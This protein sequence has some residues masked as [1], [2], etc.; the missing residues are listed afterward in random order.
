MRSGLRRTYERHATPGGRGQPS[1]LGASRMYDTTRA[2]LV[3]VRQPLSSS[4]SPSAACVCSLCGHK[5]ARRDAPDVTGHARGR[6]DLPGPA[7]R[8]EPDGGDTSTWSCERQGLV[9]QDTHAGCRD[10]V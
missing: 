4:D 9:N 8:L 2:A 6:D 3:Y 1:A 7:S 10:G 5:G